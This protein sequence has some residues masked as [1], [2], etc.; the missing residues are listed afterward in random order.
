MPYKRVKIPFYREF[1]G[2][3]WGTNTVR[4]EF[5]KYDTGCIGN[6]AYTQGDSCSSL[7]WDACRGTERDVW[8]EYRDIFEVLIKKIRKGCREEEEKQLLLE[9]G[10]ET[11]EGNRIL[12]SDRT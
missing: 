10:P 3:A 8:T 11:L 7:P 2:F 12:N 6:C 9:W 1:E 4:S 5:W